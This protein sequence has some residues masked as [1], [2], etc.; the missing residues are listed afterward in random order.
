MFV[1][2]AYQLSLLLDVPS[3]IYP[4]WH[5]ICHFLPLLEFKITVDDS[6]TKIKKT[7]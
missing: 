3:V 5:G 7:C 6:K 4:W 1:T 2:T